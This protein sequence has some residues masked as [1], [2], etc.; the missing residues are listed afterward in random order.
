MPQEKKGWVAWLSQDKRE[1]RKSE[2]VVWHNTKQKRPAPIFL[3]L[4]LYSHNVFLYHIK[5]YITLYLRKIFMPYSTLSPYNSSVLYT[6][7][8]S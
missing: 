7:Y 8:P 4:I 6:A 5:N 3:K 2:N 1:C